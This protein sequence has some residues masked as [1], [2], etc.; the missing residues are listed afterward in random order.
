MLTFMSLGCGIVLETGSKVKIVKAGDRVLLSFR[1]CK[2]CYF[3]K[4]GSLPYCS[5]FTP[6]NLGLGNQ[7]RT[8]ASDKDGA[9]VKGF[10]FGQS[11]F[12]E[13]AIVSETSIVNVSSLIQTD[14]ELKSLSPLGCGLQ[15]GAG[16]IMNLRDLNND[17]SLAVFGLGAVGLAAITVRLMSNPSAHITE[18]ESKGCQGARS[19]NYYSD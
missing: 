10:F 18:L 5:T 19:R 7:P 3:C 17:D 16:A 1:Y 2:S 14:D 4:K 12:S 9:P 11:S 13:V 6:L 15:T 8:F